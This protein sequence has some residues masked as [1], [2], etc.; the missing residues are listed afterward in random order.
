MAKDKYDFIQEMLSN[1]R[2]TN[3]QKERI[4]LFSLKEIK[5]DS[6]QIFSR[7]K[8]LELSS[9]KDIKILKRIEELEISLE[10]IKTEQS[11][12]QLAQEIRINPQSNPKHVADFM[13]LFNQREGLKYL[14]HDYDESSEFD[15][16]QFLLS[17]ND[18]FIE[19]S[20]KLNIPTSLWRIV[21]Q[22]AFDSK[23]PAW[24][25]I[26][27]DYKNFLPIKIGWATKELREWSKKNRLHPI[28]NEEYEKIISDFK[29]ITRIESPNLERLIN[30][31]LEDTLKND[32]T[33]FTVEKIDLQKA[34]FY[35]HVGFLKR[36]LEAIFEEIKKRSD[37]KTK[38][39]VTI[40]YER[41]ISDDGYYIRKIRILHHESYPE[42]ELKLILDEWHHKGN[43]GKIKQNLNG[44]CHWSVET[45][46][47]GIPQRIN[48]LKENQT[49]DYETIGE[50]VQGFTHILTFYYK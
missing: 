29:K 27:S 47:D 25:S 24:T 31:T 43:M 20:R 8:K 14:T 48:I 30:Q 13:S 23:Q 12:N 33:N 39:R 16:D 6:S 17:A 41:S 9:Q 1:T 26:S 21:K 49:L 44:Y 7:L 15:I 35:S 2:L 42:K 45:L 11:T 10:T 19:Y 34:D 5:K 18:V 46:V 3:S 38:K 37:F 4:M 40:K 28:R 22:F 36:A 32:V 50:D